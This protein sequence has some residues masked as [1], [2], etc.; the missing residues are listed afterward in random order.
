MRASVILM[1]ITSLPSK[2]GIGCLANIDKFIDFLVKSKQHYWQIL[3]INPV[4]FV[5][6]PYASSSTFAGNTLIIDPVQLVNE[7]LLTDELLEQCSHC[8]G[9]D[10]MY[11]RQNND[12]ILDYA[13]RQFV[14]FDAPRAYH[15]F[16]YSNEYWL[17]DYCLFSALKDYFGGISW[18]QWPDENIRMRNKSAIDTYS[19]LLVDRIDYYRFTQYIFYKQWDAFR[20]KL[21]RNNISLVG[22][23]PIYVAYDSADVWAHSECFVLTEDHKPKLV[24]GVP[25]DYFSADGQ[26]WGNPLY[27]WKSMSADDY[28]W[29]HNRVGQCAKLFDVLRID[30]FRAFDSYYVIKHGAPNARV[31]KWQKG[32]GI[33]FLRKII[34]AYPKLSIIAEDL[35]DIPDSVLALRDKCHLEGMKV[36]QFAFDGN[37]NN[38]FLPHHYPANCVAYLGTHDNDTTMGWW[39]SLDEHTRSLVKSYCQ[40]DNE[41]G[42]HWRL[43]DIL[44]ASM[45]NTIIISMQDIAGDGTASR[46]NLP[47][48]I[49]HWKYMADS[50]DFSNEN[51]KHLREI[52]TRNNRVV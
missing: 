16:V 23:I 30:H 36:L 24:A 29:W 27:N 50:A 45:A 21:Y 17:E 32:V 12:K 26:L 47:G 19:D 43:I 44:S 22:D 25:P 39:N 48:T 40:I 51:A 15:D 11:A 14:R 38:V 7:G 8:N 52:T 9:I 46:M 34:S 1:H 33:S 31:G 4:D 37:S 6:S 2:Y 18:E 20:D 41:V 3:P 5:N 13:Y 49:G 10:Y 42:I 35:G 28:L